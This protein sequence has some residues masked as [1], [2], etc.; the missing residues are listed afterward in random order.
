M[1]YV[2]TFYV[3]KQ[4]NTYVIRFSFG[5]CLLGFFFYY[6]AIILSDDNSINCVPYLR[7]FSPLSLCPSTYDGNKIKNC[8][9]SRARTTTKRNGTRTHRQRYATVKKKKE[10]KPTSSSYMLY[11]LRA[12]QLRRGDKTGRLTGLPKPETR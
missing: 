11:S 6:P 12:T 1:E 7:T 5:F 10:K 9:F 8:I 3:N 2:L 4:T